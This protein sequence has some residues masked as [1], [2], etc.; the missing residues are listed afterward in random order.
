MTSDH[1]RR[2]ET[3]L[4]E[5]P[6]YPAGRFEGRGIVICA[7][8]AR[9]FTC[10]WI[11][12]G[13]L[14]RVLGCRLAIQV[15]HLG[16]KEIG[17]PMRALLEGFDVEVIDALEVARDHPA[18][19]LGGW[20]L[21]SY[22]IVHSRFR[23]VFLL[24][25]D[26][27]ALVDPAGLFDL[28]EYAAHGAVFW[29]DIVQLRADNPI[30]DVCGV[31]YRSTPSIESGQL[32][33]DKQRCWQAL[34]LTLHMNQHSD[35]FYQH[36]YGDKDTFLM[37]WLRLGQSYAMPGHMP[38][39]RHGV[40]NQRDF[41]GRTIFQHRN[42]A[43]WSYGKAGNP[44]LPDFELEDEC[45]ALLEELEE[46]WNGRVFDPPTPSVP[47][48]AAAR[49]LERIEWFDYVLT[50]SK[51]TRLQ[52]LP[53]N[54]IGAGRGLS[55][56]YW[57]TGEDGEGVYLCLEGRQRPSSRLRPLPDGVWRGRSFDREAWD[58]QLSPR[59]AR[60]LPTDLLIPS[61]AAL[62]EA[63]LTG[64]AGRAGSSDGIG[65]L[66]ATF[67]VLRATIPGFAAALEKHAPPP[68]AQDEAS[69]RLRSIIAE[70]PG[71]PPARPAAPDGEPS[72]FRI[73]NLASHYNKDR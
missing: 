65:D 9:L 43:K 52:L 69:R 1:R 29:P 12:I 5:A 70:S 61:A 26:N 63:I 67:R 38:M 72:P 16:P 6:A 7:G 46:V 53:D 44:R 62:L 64:P 42:G 39:L 22:A 49:S 57:W 33:V 20:E 55:E 45:F 58:V 17:P 73:F 68:E 32:L 27:V 48:R 35:F 13:I 59:P 41:H 24:D 37:A 40:L 34:Q 11:A 14:R 71:T 50:G 60:D 54:R 10:A 36:L 47:A 2:F 28:P 3:A 8:G 30:W 31:D 56:F 4:A 51:E 23:E 21:K 15:W 18:R 25:A 66:M 19:N